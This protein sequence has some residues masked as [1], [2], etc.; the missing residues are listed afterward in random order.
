M[1]GTLLEAGSDAQRK[2][3]GDE[4]LQAVLGAYG[5]LVGIGE[6]WDVSR[7]KWKHTKSQVMC[8]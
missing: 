8:Y 2:S 1:N 6:V 7:T 4:R 5:A 3:A